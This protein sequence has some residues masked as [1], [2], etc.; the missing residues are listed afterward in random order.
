MTTAD[1]LPIP[2]PT[3]MRPARRVSFPSAAP[4]TIDPTAKTTL[5]AKITGFL[6]NRSARDIPVYNYV[7]WRMLYN[8]FS[9][10][11]WYYT[12]KVSA[13]KSKKPSSGD[14]SADDRFV[15]TGTQIHFLSANKTSSKSINQVLEM[16]ILIESVLPYN[17]HRSGDDA[18]IVTE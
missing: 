18:R 17:E 12:R 13:Y 2:M 1:D 9:N 10:D 11:W 5:A 16:R 8:L 3:I 15:P 14:G 7:I 4:I 6:P